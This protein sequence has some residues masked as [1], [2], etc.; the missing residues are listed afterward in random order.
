MLAVGDLLA[1]GS[2]VL[3]AVGSEITV[4]LK[5]IYASANFTGAGSLNSVGNITKY[6][7]GSES[8]SGTMVSDADLI[9]TGAASLAA[10]GSELSV[11][12]LELDGAFNG[13]AS[14]TI[15]ATAI[16]A[17]FAS[18]SLSGAGTIGFYVM[19]LYNGLF[20]SDLI[21]I[22]RE[23]EDGLDLRITED[24]DSRIILNRSNAASG[25]LTATGTKVPFLP[26]IYAKDDG[27]WKTVTPYVKYNGSW[28]EPQRV[29]VNDNGN[30]KRVY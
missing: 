13:N 23:T 10:T 22:Y 11:P 4:A 6:G 5:T 8:A 1:K 17:N 18:T 2:T 12:L 26:K 20:E 3:S 25:S 24:G 19:A 7:A 27:I 9:A 14:G 28:T 16:R 30:W 21:T 15:N 29:Y